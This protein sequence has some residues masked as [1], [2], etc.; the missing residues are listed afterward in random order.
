MDTRLLEFYNR[1]LL[2]AREMG[3]EFAAAYPGIAAALGLRGTDCDDPYVERLLE[4]M[5]FLAARIQLKLDAR[6]PEFTQHLLEVVYPG[7]LA[8]TPS[9]AVAEFVPNVSEGTLVSGVSIPRHSKVS[10]VPGRGERTPCQFLTAHDVVL[11]PLSLNEARYISGAGALG[12]LELRP[13][14]T[15]RAA[16][17]LKLC[18]PDGVK[19]GSLPVE[20]LA[21]FVKAVPDVAAR[22]IE[23][24]LCDCVGV[25]VREPKPAARAALL[26]G[27]SVSLIG[28]DDDESLLPVPHAGFQG[29]RLLQEYFAFPE[30][31]LSFRIEGLRQALAPITGREAELLI[32]FDKSQPTLENALDASHLRLYCTPIVNLFP[33]GADRVHVS[34]R[35]TEIHVAADR[36]RPMDYEIHSITGVRGIGSSG[37]TIADVLPLHRVHHRSGPLDSQAYFVACRRPR[38]KSS[39]QQRLGT[40]TQYLGSDVYLSVV[41]RQR[42][43]FS[44]ELR[45][46][47]VQALCTNRDLPLQ[48]ALGKSR[49]DFAF[50]GSAPIS[51][52]RCIAG[53]TTPRNSPADGDT[54]WRLISQLS[55]NYLS[56]SEEDD[57]RGAETLRGLLGVYAHVDDATATRQIEG[58]RRVRYRPAVRRVPSGGPIAYGRGLEITLGLEESAFE[59]TGIVAIAAVLERFFARYASINSFTQ[60]RLESL[61]RGEIKRWPA[62]IG[63]RQI[64]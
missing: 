11:W 47:D 4:G 32:L 3:A 31:L 27:R 22:V 5:A 25:A 53:P 37:E 52:I 14:T 40:R 63:S 2:Y 43:Q 12:S 55:L 26:P 23:Q 48:L 8:P 64:L 51:A 18:V 28:L 24:V 38:L 19:I 9:C 20:D 39:R 35:E 13:V 56:L 16:I 36:N 60:L 57:A 50:D 7:F 61:S 42:R 15:A 49:T 58:V 34:A 10:A 46:L 29:Y 62:R 41:D 59:G 17:S 30:R 33:R 1:E 44:G 6:H 21:F 54:A 45:Q